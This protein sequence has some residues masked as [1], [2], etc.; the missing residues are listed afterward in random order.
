MPK[1]SFL[2]VPY[3]AGQQASSDTRLTNSDARSHAAAISRQRREN[4]R[5][6]L[7]DL[8]SGSSSQASANLG[9]VQ[10]VGQLDATDETVAQDGGDSIVQRR[11]NMRAM[12][13]SWRAGNATADL[14]LSG[15]YRNDPFTPSSMSDFGRMATDYFMQVISPVNQPVYAIF[16]VTNVYTSYWLE[17][18]QDDGYRPMGLAMVGRIMKIMG[19]SSV[20]QDEDINANQALAMSRLRRRYSLT[21]HDGEKQADDNQIIT[22]LGLANLARY[23]GDT[24][25]YDMHRKNMKSMVAARGGLSELGHDGLVATALSQ[26]DSFWAIEADGAP[27][28][29]ESRKEHTPVYPAFPLSPD[30]RETFMKLPFGFQSLILRG[31]VSVELFEVLGRIAGANESGIESLSPGNMWHSKIRKHRDFLEACPTLACADDTP[32]IMEKCL[33]LAIFLY[34]A[35]TFTKARSLTSLFTASRAELTRLLLKYDEADY[36]QAERECLYWICA[37]CV[38][39][40]RVSEQDPSLLEAGKSLLPVLRRM[41][42]GFSS[43]NVLERF[44]HTQGLIESCQHYLEAPD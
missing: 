19:N 5:L 35:N 9:D 3:N 30:S 42:N 17:L 34:C 4:K 33:T 2:F 21:I 41:R 32:A 38:D 37:V 23:N 28:F 36:E 14:K 10:N 11:Q 1:E 12:Q 22:T 13:F 27:L 20:R 25:A 29:S 18:M 43:S 26:W 6:R 31:K 8:A 39:S 44:F 24:Q 16:D 7:H 15:G 40:W